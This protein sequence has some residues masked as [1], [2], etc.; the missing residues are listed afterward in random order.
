M[1]RWLAL[2]VAAPVFGG[3]DLEG[4]RDEPELVW[5]VHG[6]SDGWLHKP[7]A[8]AFDA[9]DQLYLADLTDR[10][11][12]FDR[13]GGFLRSWRMPAL[14][15][16]GPSGVNVDRLGRVLVADTHFYRVMIFTREGQP[17][18]AGGRWRS[19]FDAGPVRVCHGCG[20]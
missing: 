6:T 4:G 2:S 17:D 20:D 16:D 7:R 1:L 18:R 3:C 13:D 11:Q 19:G 9:E 8:A 15:I 12:V 5:G 14:N 10:I